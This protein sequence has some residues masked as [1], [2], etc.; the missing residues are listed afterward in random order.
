MEARRA[1]CCD[2][3][4][5]RQRTVT[6]AGRFHISALRVPGPK[7]SVAGCTYRHAG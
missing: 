3:D 5:E 1:R 4:E 2:G 7:V 6:F